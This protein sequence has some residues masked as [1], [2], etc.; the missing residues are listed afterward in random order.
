MGLTPLSGLP[1]STSNPNV[2]RSKVV[3]FGIPSEPVNSSPALRS[4]PSPAEPR[5]Y[6]MRSGKKRDFGVTLRKLSNQPPPEKYQEEKDPTGFV[7]RSKPPHMSLRYLTPT[8]APD[9]IDPGEKPGE[10]D[11]E[12]GHMDL[13]SK[14]EANLG[15]F[16]EFS[17]SFRQL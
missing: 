16:G 11:S 9:V 2:R 5:T 8:P 7:P 10:E 3:H 6:K 1:R 4:S 15:P 17:G 12:D 13:I 14:L